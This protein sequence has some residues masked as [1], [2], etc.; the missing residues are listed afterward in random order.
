MTL[1]FAAIIDPATPANSDK[2]PGWC[3]GRRDVGTRLPPRIRHTDG[4]SKKIA[5]AGLMN[6]RPGYYTVRSMAVAVP[7]AGGWCAFVLIGA[8]WSP[9]CRAVQKLL[10]LGNGCGRAVPKSVI[11][12]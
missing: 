1:L 4:L 9:R 11:R 8:S 5:E 10:S 2:H 12:S 3:A 7:Y 6:R